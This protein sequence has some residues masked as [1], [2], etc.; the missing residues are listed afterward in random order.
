MGKMYLLNAL[1]V[2]VKLASTSPFDS[3]TFVVRLINPEIA[4]ALID[5]A[6]KRGV[7]V[8]SAIGHEASVKALQL[9]GIHEA[10]LNR[11][12]IYFERYDE[13]IALVL[14]QRVPEGK[15]LT[16][17]EMN[18]IGYDLYHIFRAS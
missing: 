5:D 10:T 15:I 16:L 18:A 12:S 3:A 17:E 9:L 11:V 2:P 1:I 8:I 4:R 7:E 14:R 13:A 6:K